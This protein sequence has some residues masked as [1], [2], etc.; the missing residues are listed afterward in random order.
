[1][2]KMMHLAAQ[3][4]AAA[5]IS[6]LDK[7]DDDSHTNLGLSRGTGRLQTHPLSS[8][9]DIL[10]LDYTDFSLRWDAQNN[11]SIFPLNGATHAQVLTWLQETSKTILNRDYT[12]KFHYNL[13]SPISPDFTFELLSEKRLKELLDLRILAQS[14]LEEILAV[15]RLESS[16]RIWPHHFDTGIYNAVPESDITIGLGLAIPDTLCDKHYL[17]ITGYKNGTAIDPSGFNKLTLGE[18]KSEGFKGAILNTN[19]MEE[20]EGIE[21]FKE[22]INVL[23]TK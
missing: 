22:A 4:L 13:P 5:G 19:G 12:Y 23:L 9:G 8:N 10:S 3:Y 17:Y 1:M 6:F 7:K 20:S 21:F 11:S 16:I 18:W 15:Y 2:E 14:T